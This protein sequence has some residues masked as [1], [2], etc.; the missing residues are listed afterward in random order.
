MTVVE[1]LDRLGNGFLGI[2]GWYVARGFFMAFEILFK[3][4]MDVRSRRV[5]I[6]IYFET[7]NVAYLEEKVM[8]YQVKK[9]VVCVLFEAVKLG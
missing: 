6:E 9:W 1:S 3:F 8:E 2:V 4:G 5:E 7:G